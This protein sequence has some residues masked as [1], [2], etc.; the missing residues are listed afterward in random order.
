M[1]RKEDCSFFMFFMPIP[2]EVRIEEI[3]AF[4]KK[5]A[6]KNAPYGAEISNFAF[7]KTEMYNKK[8]V[9]VHITVSRAAANAPNIGYVDAGLRQLEG[10]YRDIINKFFSDYKL[11]VA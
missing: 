3:Y 7:V 8:G 1:S 11:E 9:E 6:K 5:W 10:H 4:A 2:G